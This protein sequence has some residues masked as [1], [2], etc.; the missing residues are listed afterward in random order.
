MPGFDS[1]VQVQIATIPNAGTVSNTIDAGNNRLAR[2]NIPAAFT[3]TGLTFNVAKADGV[4]MQPLKNAAG[5]A[6][7]ITV[8]PNG[9]Y[10]VDLTSF[11]GCPIF[12]IVSNA[13]EGGA[14]DLELFLVP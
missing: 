13:A 5:A 8:A 12:Q 10:V 1:S 3:G 14:R 9:A 2:I 11:F 6:I 7:A 4:T